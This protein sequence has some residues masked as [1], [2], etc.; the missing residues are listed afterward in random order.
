MLT[1]PTELPI[2]G[3]RIRA[4][5]SP[6]PAPVTFR[7]TQVNDKKLLGL[8][9]RQGSPTAETLE[10]IKVVPGTYAALQISVESPGVFLRINEIN[11]LT[12]GCPGDIAPHVASVAGKW[13]GP[14]VNENGLVY[15][16]SLDLQQSGAVIGGTAGSTLGEYFVVYSIQGIVDGDVLTIETTGILDQLAPPSNTGARRSPR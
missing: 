11:L 4:S 7:I 6:A 2:S 15:G 14:I 12:P 1:F 10:D 13:K 5:T 3:I 8:A 16:F 9:A